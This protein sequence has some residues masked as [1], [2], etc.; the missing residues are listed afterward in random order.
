MRNG[1]IFMEF[2]LVAGLFA[3]I[4]GC[5]GAQARSPER[6][7]QAFAASLSS[8]DYA[9]AY[10]LMSSSYRRRVTLDEFQRHLSDNPAEARAAVD[11]LMQPEGEAEQVAVV[12]LADGNEVELRNDGGEWRVATN[13]VDFYDQSTP[14]AALRS[15]IRAMERERYD[16]VVRFV[17]NA[18]REGMSPEA[19]R[20]AWSGDGREEITRLLTSLR[21]A[22]S[23]PIEEVGDRA[24][25]RYGDAQATVQFV[26]EGGLWKIED[27]D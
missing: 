19:M 13:V 24:T 4:Y 1:R 6:V 15:F 2:A 8:G 26:R 10:A 27:P 21:S 9:G 23:N 25:M 22:M 17:P 11:A 5:G 18:D 12:V 3:H 14:R 7:V 20:A 16:V